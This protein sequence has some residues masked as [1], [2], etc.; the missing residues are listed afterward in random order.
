MAESG[1]TEDTQGTGDPGNI[2]NIGNPTDRRSSSAAAPASAASAPPAAADPVRLVRGVCPVLEV[3]FH[4]DGTVDEPGFA[5]VV[6]E[7]LRTGVGSV[8]FPGFASEFHKLSEPERDSLTEVLLAR[9]RDRSDVA[10]VLAVQDQATHP[11]IRRAGALVAAGADLINLLPP[12]APASAALH[13][14]NIRE[15]LSAV[16]DAVAPVPVVL[17][18]APALTGTTMNVATMQEI[19]LDHPN[20][21]LVKVESVPPGPTISALASGEPKLPAL[22]GYAGVHWPDA[23]ARGAIGVQPGCSFV[24]VYLRIWQHYVAGEVEQAEDLH[25]RLLPYLSGWMSDSSLIVSAEKLI[26]HRRGWFASPHCRAPARELDRAEIAMVD[27][28]LAEF[29]SFWSDR[30]G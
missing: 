5:T 25:R 6:D 13:P 17:Q 20:L 26:S 8:L 4:D 21:R 10:A 14:A 7:V 16:L 24:E 23:A 3:P 30:V 9:T 19:A 29:G 12:Y 28:F 27:R 22:V 15:H 18:Y 11:A 1:G 2:P